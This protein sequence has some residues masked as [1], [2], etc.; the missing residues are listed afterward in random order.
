MIR[1]RRVVAPLVFAVLGLACQPNG[2][3]SPDRPLAARVELSTSALAVGPD[4]DR[5]SFTLVN[6][7]QGSVEWRIESITASWISVDPSAGT[8]SPGQPASVTVMIAREGLSRGTHVG[9]IGVVAGDE[10]LRVTV[11]LE[12]AG[13]A[14][15]ALDPGSI[16]LGSTGASGELTI[17]NTGDAALEW[18]LSGPAWVSFEPASGTT[19]PAGG[20]RVVFTVDRSLLDPGSHTARLS[21]ASNGGQPAATLTVEVPAPDGGSG[22]DSATVALEGR[23]LDQFTRSAAGGVTV[24]FDGQTVQTDADGR[25]RLT[26]TASDG[27]RSL[28]LS[29]G[30]RLTRTTFARTG[31]DQW[32]VI[33]SSFDMNAFDDMA[34]EY[35]PRTIRWVRD[36]DVYFDVTPPAGFPRGSEL[37]AWIEEVRGIL[38]SFIAGWTSGEIRAASLTVGTAPPATGTPGEIV[39]GFSEDPGVYNDARTVGLARTFWTS[40]R[41]IVSARI[42]LRFSLVS[43]PSN[44]SIRTAV[45]GH[46][47]GHALGLGHMQGSTAS[48]MTP[49]IS[50][51]NLSAFD[52]QAG[53]LLYTRSPGNTSPD[54]DNAGYYRGALAPAVAAGFHE[55][56]CDAPHRRIR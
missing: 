11:S 29:G 38:A 20:E 12:H 16:A 50:V 8:L 3:A 53:N 10:T 23:V 32:L 9:T 48:I 36:P 52:R 34:R 39:I 26:G 56:V 24:A 37:D 54:T 2:P 1:F 25:F 55:W 14:R 30:G 21:L 28:S 42:W 7:G 13:T 18:A 6:R 15:A 22:D 45:V 17:R 41:S 5:T 27:L 49:S 46:E 35:E 43:G 33:P 47:L 19:A 4:L 31:D 51:S 40:D 44:T